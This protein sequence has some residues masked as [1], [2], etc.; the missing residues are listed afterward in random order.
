MHVRPHPASPPSAIHDLRAGR[1]PEPFARKHVLPCGVDLGRGNPCDGPAEVAAF[2]PASRLHQ[3]RFDDVEFEAAGAVT[4]QGVWLEGS[5]EGAGIEDELDG[6]L[7]SFLIG[8]D[9]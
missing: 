7:L 4:R 5:W 9:Q 6:E 1:G 8:R 2:F 3:V